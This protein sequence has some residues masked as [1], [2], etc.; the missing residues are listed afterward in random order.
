MPHIIT[1]PQRHNIKE[2][3]AVCHDMLLAVAS[4]NVAFDDSM[5]SWLLFY[6]VSSIDG[7]GLECWL[8]LLTVHISLKWRLKQWYLYE[9]VVLFMAVKKYYPLEI[10]I[11]YYFANFI[12]YKMLTI[13]K[14]N[15]KI[16]VFISI[17]FWEFFSI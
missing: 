6:Y 11:I 12:K 15:V 7:N 4:E 17:T 9:F 2:L 3:M 8:E 1:S 13:F 10:C 14:R 5:L 16:H